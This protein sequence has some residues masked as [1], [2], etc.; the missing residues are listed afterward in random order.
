MTHKVL[1]TGGRGYVGGRVVQF[2]AESG[3]SLRVGSHRVGLPT[4]IW[5]KGAEQINLDLLTDKDLEA[6]C[7]GVREVVHL[8]AVNE[9]VCAQAPEQALL[10]N[11]LGTLKLLS[12]ALQAGVRR[13]IYFSTAHVYGAP[14][15]GVITEETLP[16]PLHPYAITHRVAEDFVLAAHRQRAIQGVVLRLSNGFGP[17]A[18]AHVDRWTLLVN[19]LCRQA[20]TSGKLTLRSSGLQW[21]NF[22]P[23]SDV[24]RAVKHVLELPDDLLGDGLFNLGG[25]G[26]LRVI[27]LANRIAGRCSQ[28]LNLTAPII[29]PAPEP[30]E[31]SEPLDYRLDRLES[32]GFR[33]TGNMDEEI[34]G[35]LRFCRQAWGE[36]AP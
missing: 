34:D 3:F 8:A 20:V 12:A 27:D 29:R 7:R 35:T 31:A 4:P 24:A 2:L 18:E 1:I 21:R 14:L 23:L 19:D 15:A 13:F 9:I 28:V 32:T 11:G 6:A 16:R 17:P 5:L 33:L 26:A 22:I 30:R 10:V 36:K 25:N